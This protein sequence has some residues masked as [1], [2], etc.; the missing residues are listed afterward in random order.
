MPG[1]GLLTGA[2]GETILQ[3]VDKEWRVTVRDKIIP[4][5]RKVYY[6]RVLIGALLLYGILTRFAQYL[7]NRSIWFDESLLVMNILERGY[8]ELLSPLDNVQAA[9]PVFLLLTKLLTELFGHTEYIL[10]LIP[11]ISG[12]AALFLFA[13]L[14]GR[15]LGRKALPPALALLVLSDR[16]IY[17]SAEAKQYLSLIHIFSQS[18]GLYRALQRR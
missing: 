7:S 15:L 13:K 9:P 1:T 14:A 12:I 8:L 11:F 4:A 5:L 2:S 17:Y 3:A 18:T 6:S 10:R 16:A